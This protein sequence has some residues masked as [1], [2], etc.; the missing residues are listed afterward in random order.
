MQRYKR[1]ILFNDL[2]Y[3]E[4]KGSYKCSEAESFF[5]RE[6][7]CENTLVLS[8]LES[9]YNIF[10][11]WGASVLLPGVISEISLE[12]WLNTLNI[13]AFIDCSRYC[14]LLEAKY[15]IGWT[16][17]FMA[18]STLQSPSRLPLYVTKNCPSYACNTWYILKACLFCLLQCFDDILLVK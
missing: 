6:F 8:S 16:N 12:S 5:D 1:W 4:A 10:F 7:K 18:E 11:I 2:T 15:E 17:S 3:W 14:P 9:N 13:F